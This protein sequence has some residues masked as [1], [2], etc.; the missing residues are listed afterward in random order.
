MG[1]ALPVQRLRIRKTRFQL[2]ETASNPQQC[3][4]E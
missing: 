4:G 2:I 1:K 3:W